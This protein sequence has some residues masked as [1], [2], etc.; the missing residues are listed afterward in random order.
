MGKSYLDS[1]IHI[2]IRLDV[3]WVNGR[4]TSSPCGLRL[5]A[6]IANDCRGTGDCM[7]HSLNKRVAKPDRWSESALRLESPNL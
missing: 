2:V 7:S 1:L 6:A 5:V 4:S 3:K